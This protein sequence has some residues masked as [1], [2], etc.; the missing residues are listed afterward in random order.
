MVKSSDILLSLDNARLEVFKNKSGVCVCY[1]NA[2]IQRGSFLIGAYG[3]GNDFE[4]ACDDYLSQIRGKSL[5]F[6]AYRENR[7]EVMVLG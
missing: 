6:N 1:Q 3:V 5:V 4:T 7:R 2:E